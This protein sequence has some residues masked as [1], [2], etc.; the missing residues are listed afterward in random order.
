MAGSGCERRS[1][2]SNIYGGLSFLTLAPPSGSQR[3]FVD[4]MLVRVPFGA[5]SL[6]ASWAI[7][8]DAHWYLRCPAAEMDP[9]SCARGRLDGT[10]TLL[11]GGD[12]ALV[13]TA[14]LAISCGYWQ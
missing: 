9:D 14:S 2:N 13:K 10:R 11:L 5:S 4:V 1:G 6:Q 3:P 12:D 7:V 8:F